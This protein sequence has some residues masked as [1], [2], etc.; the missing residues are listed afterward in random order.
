MVV[1]VVVPGVAETQTMVSW[2]LSVVTDRV[3]VKTQKFKEIDILKVMV[4]AIYVCL[5]EF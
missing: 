2:L 4:I 1:G 5:N 3:V